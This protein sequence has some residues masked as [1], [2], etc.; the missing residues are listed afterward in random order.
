MS[1]YNDGK[2]HGWNGGECPVHPETVVDCRFYNGNCD[3][4]DAGDY[5]W[6][7]DGASRI[8]A[9]R[10]V[11]EHKEPVVTTH[12]GECWAYHYTCMEHSLVSFNAGGNCTP[13]TWAATHVDGKLQSFTWSADND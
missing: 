1:N 10:V 3:E 11:K 7:Y 6:S 9:F 4:R 5:S 12:E 8:V 13:G 2:W